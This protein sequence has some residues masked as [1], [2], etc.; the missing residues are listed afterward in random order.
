VKTVAETTLL[1]NIEE[2]AKI[3]AIG[4]GGAWVYF[5]AIRGRTF[6]PRLQTEVSGK[7]LRQRGTQ[8]L[9]VNMQVKNIGSSIA[10]IKEEGSTLTI[11]PNN[12]SRGTGALIQDLQTGKAKLCPVFGFVGREIRAMEPGTIIY[13]QHVVEVPVNQYDA[14][15]IELRLSAPG[16]R[17]RFFRKAQKW[18]PFKYFFREK[19]PK[20]R[21]FFSK[22]NRKW[23]SFC[24][25]LE[26]SA[27]DAEKKKEG[28]KQ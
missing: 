15:Q 8:Y 17:W 23:R 18:R 7:I 19:D 14:F 6:I 24:T 16:R 4:V 1:N 9:L 21:R 27:S 11:S 22:G 20:W 26:D 12:G 13:S 5:N 2:L 10:W 3:A 28:E 25:V